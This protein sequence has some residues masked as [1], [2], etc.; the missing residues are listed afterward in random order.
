MLDHLLAACF[1][2]R[3]QG[4]LKRIQANICCTLATAMRRGATFLV[5]L[6]VGV[7]RL[8]QQQLDDDIKGYVV[9]IR[10]PAIVIVNHRHRGITKFFISGQPGL[11]HADHMTLP[12]R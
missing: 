11:G 4:M 5:R 6:P 7:V 12:P 2:R 10:M 9:V 8:G 3:N 1:R